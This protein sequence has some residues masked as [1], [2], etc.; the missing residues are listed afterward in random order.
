MEVFFFQVFVVICQEEIADID[1]VR[2]RLLEVVFEPSDANRR[3][4]VES[5]RL[6]HNRFD[7]ELD[8]GWD[9]A[10][11]LRMGELFT[12]LL[13]F[14]LFALQLLG[15]QLELVFFS[16]QLISLGLERLF[17]LWC[18]G[19][20]HVQFLLHLLLAFQILNLEHVQLIP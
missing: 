7:G 17:A 15:H 11:R 14:L 12:H 19:V 16:P 2:R 1:G 9:I 18:P 13:K 10:V 20:E 3:Q 6:S 5:P 8:G 4:N